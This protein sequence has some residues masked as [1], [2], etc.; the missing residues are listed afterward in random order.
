MHMGNDRF[1]NEKKNYENTKS[2]SFKDT[3]FSLKNVCVDVCPGID[4]FTL[5]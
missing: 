1:I 5:K 3:N 4:F 2:Q